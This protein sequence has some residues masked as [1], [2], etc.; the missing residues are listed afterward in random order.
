MWNF[1][2]HVVYVA[3]DLLPVR[4]WHKAQFCCLLFVYSSLAARQSAT[5]RGHTPFLPLPLAASFL[6]FEL[7]KK[8]RVIC[9]PS[10]SVLSLALWACQHC[11]N[12]I[13]N[14][15]CEAAWFANYSTTC[16]CCCCQ[17]DRG[18]DSVSWL[19]LYCPVWPDL[20]VCVACVTYPILTH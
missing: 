9:L 19:Y 2:R 6:Y 10:L 20:S 15:R 7:T 8:K 18:T 11:I 17:T 3:R 13:F 4:V 5:P 12:P 14:L 16:C 1:V